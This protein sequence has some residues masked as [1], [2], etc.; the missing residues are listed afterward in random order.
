MTPSA[1][2]KTC[3]YCQTPIKPGVE[4]VVCSACKIPHHRECWLHNSGCATFG[5]SSSAAVISTASAP[6]AVSD[7]LPWDEFAEPTYDAPRHPKQKRHSANSAIFGVIFLLLIWG[8]AAFVSSGDSSTHS[9]PP[10]VSYNETDDRY[11]YSYTEQ[12][13]D[14]EEQ[15]PAE[16]EDAPPQE[17]YVMPQPYFVVNE[18]PQDFPA[19]Q[20]A[21]E[22][23]VRAVNLGIEAQSGSIT[24]SFNGDPSIEI[25]STDSP[26][27]R[28]WEIGGKIGQYDDTT[29]NFYKDH[30]PATEPGAESYYRETWGRGG[31]RYLRLRVRRPF[32]WRLD[33]K[34]RCTLTLSDEVAAENSLPKHITYPDYRRSDDADQQGLPVKIFRVHFED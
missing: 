23:V 15:E 28:V 29:G 14:D 31:Q 2:G 9:T 4:V 34:I 3:P 18:L 16:D 24:V 22:F 7:P 26:H 19:D 12:Q 11:D 25:V 21:I 33:I 17:S 20:E 32:P 27:Q 8:A 6:T 5:C 13:E 30:M 10:S 1:V